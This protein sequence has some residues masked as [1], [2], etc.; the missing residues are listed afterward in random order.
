MKFQVIQDGAGNSAG[1]FITIE[2]WTLIKANYPDIE[3]LGSQIPDWQKE[4]L[5]LRINA[6]NKN[7]QQLRPI[8]ELFDELDREI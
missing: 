2:D 1:V 8:D 3:T 5:D 4:L 6:I 7:P